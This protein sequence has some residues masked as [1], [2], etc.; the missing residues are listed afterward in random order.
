MSR[1]QQRWRIADNSLAILEQIYQLDRFPAQ[2]TRNELATTLN[3]SSRQIQVWFQNRRQRD[4]KLE[5]LEHQLKLMRQELNARIAEAPTPGRPVSAREALKQDGGEADGG[6]ARRG[7][8]GDG[9]GAL[10]EVRQAPQ[11][12]ARVHINC[13][14]PGAAG[15]AKKRRGAKEDDEDDEDEDQDRKRTEE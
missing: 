13:P 2:N 5:M 7:E 6:G 9:G 1:Q 4:R 10:A 15:R 3:V 8:A 11:K 12:R 14:A